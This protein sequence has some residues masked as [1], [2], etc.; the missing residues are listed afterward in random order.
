M[1]S[2]CGQ[3]QKAIRSTTWIG[4]KHVELAVGVNVAAAAA[5]AGPMEKHLLLG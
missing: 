1:H 4:M 3:P 5:A 2:S